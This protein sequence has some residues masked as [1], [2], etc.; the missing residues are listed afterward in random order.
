MT[1]HSLRKKAC[2]RIR[3][4]VTFG[5]LKEPQMATGVDRR[6]NLAWMQRRLE[7]LLVRVERALF[8]LRGGK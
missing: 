8:S 7:L 2:P 6:L 4:F 5:A 1:L 3:R